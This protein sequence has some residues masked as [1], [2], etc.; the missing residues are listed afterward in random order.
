MHSWSIFGV[1]TSH[2][3]IQ[4]HKIHHGSDLG[5]LYSKPFHDAHIQMAFVPGLPSGS[6]EIAKVG[7][8]VTLEPHN[9]A[10]R[11]LI[12]MSLKQSCSSC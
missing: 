4:I 8:I 1:R 7:T 10:C 6:F 11:P 2:R 5:E 9:F 3:Q 12:E